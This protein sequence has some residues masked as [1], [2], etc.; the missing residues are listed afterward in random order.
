VVRGDPA[1]WQ[2][3]RDLVERTY[4]AAALERVSGIRPLSL[5]SMDRLAECRVRLEG[6]PA[7][8][9]VVDLFLLGTGVDAALAEQELAPLAV[10]GLVEAGVLEVDGDVVR[11]RVSIL[12]FDGL[13]LV[14]DRLDE[15]GVPEGQ[16][17]PNTDLSTLLSAGV[18]SRRASGSMLDLGTGTGVHALRAARHCT[19][20]VGVDINP[21]ALMYARFNAGL[22]DVATAQW[23]EGGFFD[24]LDD[25]AFDL[26]VANPPF[27]IAP[28]RDDPHRF[29]GGA[30]DAL[31][32]EVVRGSAARLREGGL[33]YV[34]C[35]VG[36]R[37]GQTWTE[38]LCDW[39]ESTGCDALMLRLSSMSA[40]AYAL[41]N[42]DPRAYPSSRAY[43]DA[44]R[45]W[46]ESYRSLGIAE[47]A[48]A[49]IV[50][51]RRTV[52][53]N[54]TEGF[55]LA[56]NPIGQVGE[57]ID[58]VLAG[59][60][61]FRSRPPADLLGEALTLVDGHVL[62]QRMDRVG[63]SYHPGAVQL[64]VPG[65]PLVGALCAEGVPVLFALDGRRGL[66]AV[67][68]EVAKEYGLPEHYLRDRL[69]PQLRELGMRGFLHASSRKPGE[70]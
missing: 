52:P 37:P 68:A 42:H 60:D 22:N 36:V 14:G 5:V 29:G 2:G 18:V 55:A 10:G 25:R 65:F 35:D 44:T 69:L 40:A 61:R 21:R 13:W 26:V 45:T 70:T 49:I 58:R 43:E 56:G 1:L 20:V 50:L 6:D 48:S 12:P 8:T 11:G 46:R 15:R 39:V 57:H 7:R 3:L 19:S 62:H 27:I 32:R 66:G 16:R 64:Q 63:G 9:A 47:I 38:P 54:W 17:V 53:E 33:A 24:H 41:A 28:N 59:I 23:I 67:I 34:L 30:G 51:R 31:S 4:D